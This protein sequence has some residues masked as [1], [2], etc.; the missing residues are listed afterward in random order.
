MYVCVCLTIQNKKKKIM[1]VYIYRPRVCLDKTYFAE[2]E[3]TVAK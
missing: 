1:C 3:N 2:T